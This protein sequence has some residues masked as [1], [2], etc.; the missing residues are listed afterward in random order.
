MGGG[1]GLL[2]ATEGDVCVRRLCAPV[3]L[4]KVSL[5]FEKLL[6]P[7]F[8]DRQQT[9][10]WL[11]EK[12]GWDAF[13]PNLEFL[14]FFPPFFSFKV[15]GGCGIGFVGGVGSRPLAAS[16]SPRGGLLHRCWPKPETRGR[17]RVPQ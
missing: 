2:P 1:S 3:G 15:P 13:P 9:R 5:E 7:Y 4:E 10:R 16:A 14:N 17:P 6:A 8:F 11:G 12:E